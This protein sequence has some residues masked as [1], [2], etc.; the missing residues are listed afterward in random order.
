MHKIAPVGL[1]IRIYSSFLDAVQKAL[2]LDTPFM[3]CFFTQQV[4][5][6]PL[7]LSS[8]EIKNFLA[9]YRAHFSQL[10]AHGSYVINLAGTHGE[11]PVL[12]RE[13]EL[14]KRL[15]F[16]HMIIHPGSAKRQLTR[17]AGIENLVRA[18]NRL[19]KQETDI[20]FV[21]ENVAQA[22]MTIGG[23]VYDFAQILA[24]IDIP[25]RLKF[26][27]DTAHAHSYGYDLISERGREVFVAHVQELISWDS[28]AI[29]HGND[30][31]QGCGSHIDQHC[32]LGEGVLGAEAL[33]ALLMHPQVHNKPCILELP[34][35][36]EAQELALL[37][38]V[39]TWNSR[40]S[41]PQEKR[42]VRI[43]P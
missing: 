27:I 39:R 31:R 17:D 41:I 35:L 11:Q 20:T 18:L 30:T 22:G 43:R 15:S 2:R 29:V 23:E 4:M 6:K 24:R 40:I 19:I 5:G 36:P 3:Q 1:H 8:R 34:E 38:M 7:V 10:Y 26:C 32:V 33:H 25:E 13:L 12:R 16:T 42:V 21:L 28:V 9:T 14:A 37:D